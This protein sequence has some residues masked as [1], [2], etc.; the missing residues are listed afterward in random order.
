M[1]KGN[2]PEDYIPN[3]KPRKKEYHTY[4]DSMTNNICFVCEEDGEYAGIPID[5]KYF[6]E[7]FIK[8]EEI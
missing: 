6:K 3:H 7:R 5:S 8:E 2:V 1:F 4:K